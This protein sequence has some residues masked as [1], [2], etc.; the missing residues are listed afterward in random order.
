MTGPV[1][2][3]AP[4]LSSSAWNAS[5]ANEAASPLRLRI[6]PRWS[7]TRSTWRPN[8][9]AAHRAGRTSE[10]RA[11]RRVARATSV[12]VRAGVAAARRAGVTPGT[13]SRWVGR[14]R[15]SRTGSRFRVSIVM[16]GGSIR[17]VNASSSE[18]QRPPTLRVAPPRI[19]PISI[20]APNHACSPTPSDFGVRI[21]TTTWDRSDFRRRSD[22][23][24]R[25]SD[26]PYVGR[27]NT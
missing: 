2:L 3:L 25:A 26:G 11:R 20:A 7:R 16:A 10:R 4:S 22:S 21:R 14:R 8:A 17:D 23:D 9:G 1:S 18:R 19:R 27:R 6:G 24:D 12:R 15:R 13:R 5:R